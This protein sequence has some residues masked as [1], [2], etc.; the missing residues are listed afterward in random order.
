MGLIQKLKGNK[1]NEDGPSDGP[2]EWARIAREKDAE[3]KRQRALEAV[4]DTAVDSSGGG[5][6]PI[7]VSHEAKKHFSEVE[8]LSEDYLRWLSRM[9]ARGGKYIRIGDSIFV[10]PGKMPSFAG[11]GLMHKEILER[12]LKK[13]EVKERALGA[14]AIEGASE[15]TI[16]P[17]GLTDAGKFDVSFLPEDEPREDGIRGRFRVFGASTSFGAAEKKNRDRTVVIAADMLGPHIRVEY[18]Q[19]MDF[20]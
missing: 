7:N 9:G 15:E 1:S 19:H 12:V 20:R 8:E 18:A 5:V 4:G 14:G 13:P 17:D 6:S 2:E 3:I 16:G 10:T 11:E